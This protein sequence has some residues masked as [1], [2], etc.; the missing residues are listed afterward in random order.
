MS[1]TPAARTGAQDDSVVRGIGVSPGAAVGPVAQV[2]PAVPAPPDEP[3]PADR[4]AEQ[5]RVAQAFEAVARMLDDRAGRATGAAAEILT[6]ASMIARD[7]GL[8][9]AVGA[10]LTAGEGPATAVTSAVAEFVTRFEA[11]GGYFAERVTDL[12]DVRDRVVA[13]LLGRPDPGIPALTRPSVLVAAD[14]APAE[15]ATL[16]PALVVAIVT[17]RGGRT[18]HTAILAAQMGIPAIVRYP[19]ATA[20][21]DGTL[22]AVDADTGLVTVDPSADYQ[23]QLTGRRDRLR[24]AL[25]GSTGPGTTRDGHPVAL[26]ANIGSVDDAV[27][28]AAADLEGVGLFRTEFVFLSRESAPTLAEQ[29]EIY[30]Q[31]LRPFGDRPVTVRTLDA[32]A[33]KPLA[34]ADLG[35]ED[36]PALGKRGLRLSALRQDLLDTQLA[37][38]HAAAE[39]TGAVVKVMAPMV[40]TAEEAAWF[41][42]RTRENALPSVGVMIEVP[43]AALRAADLL[44]EV[45]FASLGTNDLAQYTMAADRLDGHLS[46]LLDPWQ[47]AVLSLVGQACAGAARAG[48][49]LGVCGEAAGDPLLALVL[50]GL[51]VSSLSMAPTKIPLVRYALARHD[52]AGCRRLAAL[53]LEPATAQGARQ[54]VL[55]QADPALV[56]LL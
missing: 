51:G 17:E 45:D 21:P 10:R 50:T 30:T 36:N 29:T 9:Q 35:P 37:A 3:A 4:A 43:A 40:A 22:V 24:S 14:L 13:R 18:S 33:D 31:V 34:F 11:L 39:A 46:D 56:E 42:R 53:A 27:A 28:A 12:V 41:A 44:A 19:G 16:D 48:R 15:T 52:L 49:P 20:L 23:R 38:L 55:A 47:P 25:A 8:L 32:G 1:G 5:T 2:R 54:A 7:P 6:A 26:L